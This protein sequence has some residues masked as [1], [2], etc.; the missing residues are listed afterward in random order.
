MKRL[1][2]IAQHFPPTNF[3]GTARPY[4]FARYLAEF[5]YWPVVVSGRDQGGHALD[6]EPLK[7]LAGYLCWGLPYGRRRGVCMEDC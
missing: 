1:L 3:S 5:G 6:Y 4:G 2:M 7:A